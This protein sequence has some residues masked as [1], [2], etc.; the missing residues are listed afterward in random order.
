MQEKERLDRLLVQRGLAETGEKARALILAGRVSVDGTPVSK[1]GTG[2]PRSADIQIEKSPYSFVS[3]GGEKLEG[4]F[5]TFPVDVKGKTCVDIGASTGGFTDCLLKRG[6]KKVYAIDVG[7]G[8]LDWKLRNDSRVINMEKVNV[9]HLNPDVVKEKANLATVDVSF[10]SLKLVLPVLSKI[11]LPD[12]EI[13][14]LV[15][16]Q[17]EVGK[18][19]VEKK[20]I[21]K[22]TAKHKK[23][24]LEISGFAK[25]LGWN[26]KGIAKSPI[27]GAKGN[28]EFFI[29]LSLKED[30]PEVTDIEA[31]VDE[32]IGI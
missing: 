6:A 26:I 32:L 14:A 27:S 19:E 31:S 11:L 20:G 25:E 29:Y 24:L 1:A 30:S 9:R 17:F 5:N 13:I 10:I 8:Q 4:F 16:P 28:V 12:G 15:K 22:D 3:R 18:K 21:I 23:V 2:I 7:Y